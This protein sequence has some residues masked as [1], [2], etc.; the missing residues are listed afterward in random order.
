MAVWQFRLI[1]P[2]EV[3][4]S[5]YEIL[6]PAVPQ[7]LA[8]GFLTVGRKTTDWIRGPDRSDSSQK[9]FMVYQWANVGAG[10]PR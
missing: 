10:G 2:E 3:L 4:L 6:P 8:E 1:L 9:G 7:E 5:S